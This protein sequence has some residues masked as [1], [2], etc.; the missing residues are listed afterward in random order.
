M[1]KWEWVFLVGIPDCDIL[2]GGVFEDE[3][4]SLLLFIAIED[5]KDDETLSEDIEDLLEDSLELTESDI[6]LADSS[7]SFWP[8]LIPEKLT[9]A[10]GTVRF[11]AAPVVGLILGI[12]TFF[13]LVGLLVQSALSIQF[14]DN[15]FF[16]WNNSKQLTK[17]EKKNIGDNW[18]WIKEF[19][20]K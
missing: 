17:Y 13:L 4:G 1:K 5:D 19:N 6:D 18:K 10:E 2:M 3:E 7:S 14:F 15:I 8:F 20:Q 12:S 9:L 16:K 11:W